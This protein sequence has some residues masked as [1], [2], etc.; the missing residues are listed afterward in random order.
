MSM[1]TAA[2][3]LAFLL[4]T[5][6]VAQ[7]PV[8]SETIEVRVTNLDVVVTDRSGQP[9]PG[10][11]AADFEVI[12]AGQPQPITNFSEINEP[13]VAP[14]AAAPAETATPAAIPVR[15]RIIVFIDNTSIAP[16]ARKQ[17]LETFEKS[18]DTLMRPG[19]EAMLVFFTGVGTEVLTQLTADRAVLTEQLRLAARRSGGNS[20]IQAQKSTILE[21]A[22]VLEEQIEDPNATPIAAP[23]EPGSG[24]GGGG[25]GE[26]QPAKPGLNRSKQ[27]LT[28]SE[29][30]SMA[31]GSADSLAVQIWRTQ[32]SLIEQ[33]AQ[34]IDAIAPA[35]GKKVLLFIGGELSDNPGGELFGKIDQMFSEHRTLVRNRQPQNR[36]LSADLR[37]LAQ[38]ANAADITM[39][40]VDAGDRGGRDAS[41]GMFMAAGHTF[42]SAD[43]T[44]AFAHVANLTGGATGVG[45]KGFQNMLNTIA[46]DLSAYYSI[47]YR[48]ART[49]AG[50]I[51]VRVK[52]PGAVV[53]T[54]RTFAAR[55]A[56][57]ALRASEPAPAPAATSAPAVQAPA[58]AA[59]APLVTD[60]SLEGRLKANVFD[61]AHSDFPVSV[62]A[63]APVA[64]PNGRF[65]VDLTITF[66]TSVKFVEE[67]MEMKGRVAILL[68]TANAEGRMSNISNQVQEL[69]FPRGSQKQLAA[70]KTFTYSIPLIVG[71][72]KVTVSVAVADQLAGSSGFARTV[73]TS[74]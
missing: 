27:R 5:A 40:M 2:A 60:D 3:A 70:Q 54:R 35:E 16:H 38:R 25:G 45:G 26:G 14:G 1:K 51:E 53:R 42:E 68:V 19:D 49:A 74:P 8:S 23:Q 22:A 61:P 64:Q 30:Y 29:A 9:I 4:S 31:M 34:I 58:T 44:I 72:G 28:P 32:K 73:I 57:P 67:G 36:S 39:Y 10:L 48:S 56:S 18:L 63:S 17:M 6:L 69:T 20:A 62:T 50:N 47:G 65:Q 41:S 46:R 43:T 24:G 66:P 11:T 15:R 71:A 33:L 21:N 59:P 12:E 13:V 52:R 7:Q 37:T 55:G